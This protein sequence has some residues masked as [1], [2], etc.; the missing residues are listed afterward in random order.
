MRT[1]H[2]E[3]EKNE[4]KEK[5]TVSMHRQFMQEPDGGGVDNET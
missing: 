3:D 4:R 1:R 2:F 5:D